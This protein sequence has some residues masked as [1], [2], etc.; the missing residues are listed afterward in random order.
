[1]RKFQYKAKNRLGQAVSGVYEAESREIAVDNLRQQGFFITVI[2]EAA[3][4]AT[5]NLFGARGKL[6]AK[7]LALFCRQFALQ[8]GVGLSLVRSLQLQQEQAPDIRLKKA[9]EQ[10]R[11][12]VSSGTPFTK[13]LE[14]HKSL[15]PH[16]F[17]HL[18]EAGEIAGA[19]P[20]VLDRLA[21]YYEREDELRKKV[22][23]ALMYPAIISTVAVIMVFLLVFFVLPMLIGNFASF[24]VQ[25][26]PLTQAVLDAR[27][28]LIQYWYVF[29]ASIVGFV[30][31]IKWYINTASGKLKIHRLTLILPI[32][33]ALQK[34]VIYSRFCRTLSLMLSSGISMI[35]SLQILERLIDNKVIQI[36]ISEARH[37]VEKGQGLSGPLANH[38]AFTPMLVQMFAIGEE[39]GSLEDVLV[40][41]ADY[42]DREVNY[43]VSSFTKLLEPIVMI[44]L[45]VVV[46]FILLSV[47]LPMMQMVTAL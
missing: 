47:Y 45:A 26:P 32:L 7:F 46:L 38:R 44:V 13:S 17:I 8:L 5:A 36:A 3:Q 40:Q 18:V 14:K 4:P 39:T 42:Y 35:Q 23:E 24:G 16:V 37:G 30:F 43:A 34:M 41:L 9:L 22:S 25:P 27:L 1:M 15:F 29:L 19:L 12:E 11:L 21:I 10:I 33:G 2:K 31:L 28:V 20:E 6:K